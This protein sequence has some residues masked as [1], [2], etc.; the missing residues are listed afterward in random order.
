MFITFTLEDA[1]PIILTVLGF[2]W[3]WP[4]GL[5]LSPSFSGEGSSGAGAIFLTQGIRQCFTEIT[6]GTGG[7]A[8]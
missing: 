3:W 7:T 4:I 2:L 6:V 1:M 5:L 8:R